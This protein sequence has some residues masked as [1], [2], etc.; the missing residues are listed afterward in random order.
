[1]WVLNFAPEFFIKTSK[2][3]LVNLNLL[4]F[5]LLVNLFEDLV[6][7]LHGL[8][9][10]QVEDVALFRAAG[11]RVVRQVANL[12]LVDSANTDRRDL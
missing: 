6:E 11:V 3:G 8:P 10:H 12:V 1:M 5:E 4:V 9:G 2:K 7:L